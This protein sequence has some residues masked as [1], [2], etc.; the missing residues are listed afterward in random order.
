VKS[1]CKVESEAESEAE[2]EVES[3]VASEI[4]VIGGKRRM[5]EGTRQGPMPTPQTDLEASSVRK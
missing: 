2:S 3:G 4:E 1:I 5:L